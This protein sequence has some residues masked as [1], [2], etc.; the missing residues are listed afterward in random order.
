MNESGDVP[1]ATRL[2]TAGRSAE[3][4][5]VA[6]SVFTATPGYWTLKRSVSAAKARLSEG[7]CSQ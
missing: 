2:S 1:A 4:L 5:R 6:G 7:D 3:A